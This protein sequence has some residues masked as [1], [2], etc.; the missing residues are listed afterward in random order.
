MKNL[1]FILLLLVG[2]S[3]Q[4]PQRATKDT[5]GWVQIAEEEVTAGLQNGDTLY[6]AGGSGLDPDFKDIEMFIIKKIDFHSKVIVGYLSNEES[7][8]TKFKFTVRTFID[9]LSRRWWR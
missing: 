8:Y 4:T 1:L 9:I 7:N 6:L 2:C 3:E 5:R